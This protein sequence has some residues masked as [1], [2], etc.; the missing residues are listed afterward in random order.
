MLDINELFIQIVKVFSLYQIISQKTTITY[1]NTTEFIEQNFECQL[2]DDNC[3]LFWEIS[4]SR[5]EFKNRI[6]QSKLSFLS[7]KYYIPYIIYVTLYLF[8]NIWR[9]Q[10]QL[11]MKIWQ[12]RKFDLFQL[13]TCVKAF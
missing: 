7:I 12:K 9:L 10:N 1:L 3:E 8:G 11:V 5:L 6:N 2:L 13:K 4:V